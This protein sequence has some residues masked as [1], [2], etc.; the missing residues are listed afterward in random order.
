MPWTFWQMLEDN[1]TLY[2]LYIILFVHY[3]ICIQTIHYITFRQYIFDNQFFVFRRYIFDNQVFVFSN[4]CQNKDSED[5][6]LLTSSRSSMYLT[7]AFALVIA[8]GLKS[9][10]IVLSSS[11]FSGHFGRYLADSREFGISNSLGCNW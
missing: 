3:I 4:M 8:S 9:F 5:F 10:L 6:I 2:Y 11:G 1:N 7:M